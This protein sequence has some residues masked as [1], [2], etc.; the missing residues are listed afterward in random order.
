MSK[1]V[2]ARGGGTED[3]PLDLDDEHDPALLAAMEASV[4]P[5]DGGGERAFR[6][7]HGGSGSEPPGAGAHNPIDADAELAASLAGGDDDEDGFAQHF[8]HPGGPEASY[9]QAARRAASVLQPA[10]ARE[11]L[12]REQQREYD[13]SLALDRAR[14]ESVAAEDAR[15]RAE[16]ASAEAA[17]RA[18][19]EA[20]EAAQRQGE[21]RLAAERARLTAEP[22]A[23]A[24]GVVT[25][26]VR[27]PEGG[28]IMRRFEKAQSVS[29]LYDWVHVAWAD[30]SGLAAVPPRFTVV[31][32]MPRKAH[33]DRSATLAESGLSD[34]QC[35]LFVEPHE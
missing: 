33:D 1:Q 27:L 8:A 32:H 13:A 29:L 16:A 25:V 30:L 21:A 2:A 28:R 20:A 23:G 15:A 9:A 14:D 7:L 31:S 11:L 35:A 3:D 19:A 5:G 34:R 6:E 26:A 4:Q 17:A 18:L 24:D 22:L 10:S 12:L